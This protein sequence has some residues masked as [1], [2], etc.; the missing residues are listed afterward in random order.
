MKTAL[1]H[2][3]LVS[4]AGG[5]ESVLR[6]M[7][8]LFPS[9]I[10]TLMHRSDAWAGTELEKARIYSSLIQTLPFSKRNF[11]LYFPLFPW[12]MRRFNLKEYDVVLSSSHC[13]AK[14]VKIH[15]GQLHICY[16]HSPMRYLWDLSG[17]Y[18]KEAG[19]NRG[20]RS[21]LA[22]L[23]L[24]WMRTWDRSTSQTVH[25]YI[26]NS[27]FVAERILRIYGRKAD[28][29]YPP[30]DVEFFQIGRKKGDFYLA[31]SRLVAYKKIDAIIDAFSS[32][33]DRRLVVMGDG[34]EMQGLKKRAGKNVEL[35]GQLS[36][37]HMRE[38]LQ[39]AKA[40]IFAAVEDFGILP[41]EAMACGTPVIALRQ[42][43]AVETVSENVSGMFFEE[44]TALAIKEAVARFETMGW[45]R[46]MVRAQVLKFAT[47]RFR[48][49]YDSYVRNKTAEFFSGFLKK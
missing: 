23:C 25:Y 41:V 27:K 7:H 5:A 17:F 39:E 21:I 4:Q 24:R 6:Q 28:V 43:G 49:E 47:E 26:A 14:G 45:E 1:V 40:F 29:I 16:C 9:P 22:G 8:A 34:P 18:F 35:T 46:E 31:G 48:R 13:V 2:D 19:L 30:V 33:P 15:R 42:G 3:W 20:M 44:Q 37:E 38:L 10:Y 36:G 32:M 12:A 11:R